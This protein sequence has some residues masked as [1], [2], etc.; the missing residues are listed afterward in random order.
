MT[1][2]NDLM[3]YNNPMRTYKATFTGT[4]AGVRMSIFFWGN[5]IQPILGHENTG[6]VIYTATYLA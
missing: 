4:G 5:T 2:S 6:I 1:S 3:I